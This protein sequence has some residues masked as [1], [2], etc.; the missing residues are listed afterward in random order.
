M[1][2]HKKYPSF[3]LMKSYAVDELWDVSAE[4]FC[5][6]SKWDKKREE[7]HN[8]NHLPV[9]KPSASSGGWTGLTLPSHFCPG[10]TSV[11]IPEM[12]RPR[13]LLLLLLSSLVTRSDGL[14][15]VAIHYHYFLKPQIL[16]KI[17]I[18]A[19]VWLRSWYLREILWFNQV[20]QSNIIR[21][22]SNLRW[23]QCSGLSFI[24]STNY[25]LDSKLTVRDLQNTTTKYKVGDERVYV[26]SG[27][28]ILVSR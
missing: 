28:Q 22:K 12:C 20:F 17:Q 10:P 4:W 18:T 13:S 25:Y 1:R 9:I 8:H 2:I 3:I 24:N 27:S 7:S 14:R 21:N 26:W 23:F 16:V 15:W 11:N 19:P 5:F 6:K